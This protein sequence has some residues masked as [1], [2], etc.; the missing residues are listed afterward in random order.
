VFTAPIIGA[1]SPK[2]R[3]ISTIIRSR[4]NLHTRSRENLKSHKGTQLIFPD[5]IFLYL[6]SEY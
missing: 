2:Y 5:P 1:T 6:L 3:S 4:Q